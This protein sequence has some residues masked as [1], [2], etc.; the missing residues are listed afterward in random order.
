MVDLSCLCTLPLG[1]LACLRSLARDPG[2]EPPVGSHPS[3]LAGLCEKSLQ[4]VTAAMKLK[5]AYFLQEK[6]DKPR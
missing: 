1:A 6:Y 4:M 2:L 5:D 3:R